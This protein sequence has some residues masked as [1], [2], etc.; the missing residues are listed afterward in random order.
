MSEA[1][2]KPFSGRWWI[3][4]SVFVIAVS[5]LG[6]CGKPDKERSMIENKR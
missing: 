1:K 4:I 5:I 3:Y 2:G 6:S